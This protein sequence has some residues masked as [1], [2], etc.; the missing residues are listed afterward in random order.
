[1]TRHQFTARPRRAGP[2]GRKPISGPWGCVGSRSS[3]V[4]PAWKQWSAGVGASLHRRRGAG[5]P[6]ARNRPRGRPWRHGG[7]P[8]PGP[9]RPGAGHPVRPREPAAQIRHLAARRAE[10]PVRRLLGVHRQRSL[11]SR[12]DPGHG[13]LCLAQLFTQH[14]TAVPHGRPHTRDIA[15]APPAAVSKPARRG[16]VKA[17]RRL[18]LSTV[19]GPA[20]HARR[21][22]EL[23]PPQRTRGRARGEPRRSGHRLPGLGE[24]RFGRRA[25]ATRPASPTSPSTCCS[26]APRRRGVGQIAQE[27]EGAGGE[28]N[29]W[30]SYDETAYHLV[31][32]SPFFDTGLDILAD[33][34]RHSAF[35]P[36]ELER[37]RKVVLEEI[38]QGQDD[39]D[40]MAA[41][42]L[43]Q[44]AFDQ[45]PYGRPIIGS[46]ETVRALTARS[47]VR[48]LQAALRRLATSRWWWWATSTPTAPAPRSNTPSAT[49][50]AARSPGRARRSRQQGAARVRAVARDVKEC[51]LL[52]GF[53]VPAVDHEDIPALDLLAVVLGQGESSRLNLELVRNRQLVTTAS[54]YTF[55]DR[56]PGLFVVGASLPPGRLE[57]ATR[58]AAGR[59][60]APRPRGGE[61]R[62]DRQE[63][64]PAG[65][66]AGVRQGDRPGLRPQAGLLRGHRR[67]FDVRGPVLPAPGGRGTGAA[68]PGRRALPARRRAEPVRPD[69][70]GRSRA[71]RAA[72]PGRHGPPARRGRAGRP[73]PTP[74]PARPPPR[75]CPPVVR[76]RLPGGPT[77]AGAARSVRA[78]R[79]PARRLGRGPALRDAQRTTASATW[80]PR[81]SPAAPPA[82]PPSRSCTAWRAWPARCP[83]S[84]AATAWAS[85]PSSSPATCPRAWTW[86]PTA[87]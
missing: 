45:H 47:A 83:A 53:H 55:A 21:H 56:N 61:R 2:I 8:R 40:R 38:K 28:I 86:W 46:P 74:A 73:A 44:T 25:A 62:G 29:A 33:S 31:M 16:T 19:G 69:P 36:E 57:S 23:P 66:R 43:F 37:E 77:R 79:R 17:P 80:W 52:L 60:P 87:C 75:R 20:G 72:R 35:D 84:P 27:V 42:G 32:A 54:A 15:K 24:G 58:V 51:Q 22:R 41:Q 18:S 39:P 49:C 12:T 10:R 7:C 14:H 59:D 71:P 34:L 50:P 4:S 70:R 9:P 13:S 81:C 82:A 68:A 3:P 76:K 30:T 67:R 1:M 65:E 26:R 78:H 6:A 85:R 63:Q 48:V 64:E 11:A 5:H